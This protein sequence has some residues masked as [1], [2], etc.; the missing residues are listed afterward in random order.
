MR[1]RPDLLFG[2]PASKL[3]P[4]PLGRP[5]PWHW[6][7]M[8]NYYLNGQR[9]LACLQSSRKHCR[10]RRWCGAGLQRSETVMDGS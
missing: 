2:H 5:R 9:R 3:G 1:A 10:E 8:G 4:H 7:A 6:V